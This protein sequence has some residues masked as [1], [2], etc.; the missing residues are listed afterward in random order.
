MI[1]ELKKYWRLVFVL[2]VLLL[3]TCG[4]TEP[5]RFSISF[6]WEQAPK[7]TV[8]L[9]VRI[10]ERAD[11]AEAG[12]I[13]AS[14]GPV[15]YV[16]GT[17]VGLSLEDVPNGDDRVVVVE[18]REGQDS[19]LPIAYFGLSEPFSLQPGQKG[20]VDVLVML[21][22]PNALLN[23]A[24]LKLL[25]DG[26]E[27]GTVGPDAIATATIQTWS[28]DA[29][30]VLLARD[31]SFTVDVMKVEL[32]GEDLSACGKKYDLDKEYTVCETSGVDLAGGAVNPPDGSYSIFAR[33]IDSYGYQS[34]VYKESV[35]LDSTGPQVITASA[36]PPFARAG[37][38]VVFSLTT[39]EPLGVD[40]DGAPKAVLTVLLLSGDA[41]TKPDFGTA[42]RIGTSNT[43]VWTALMPDSGIDI[44]TFG[45]GVELSD[46]VGNMSL[47]DPVTDS[48]NNT[49][50]LGVDGQPPV[51]VSEKT[52]QYSQDL[53]GLAGGLLVLDF[54]LAEASP[55]LSE[56]ELDSCAEGCPQ[57]RLGNQSVGE[58]LRKPDLDEPSLNRWGFSYSYSVDSIPWGS[59]EKDLEVSIIWSDQAGN[60]MEITLPETVRI[61]FKRPGCASQ[62][63]VPSSG[64]ATASFTYTL[65][66]SE[67][68]LLPPIVL[69]D[70]D[71]TVFFPGDSVTEAEDGQTFSWS[72]PAVDLVDG[73]FE[74]SAV[75]TDLAGNTS[76][77]P[78]CQVSAL[79]DSLAPSVVGVVISVFDGEL[80]LSPELPLRA[81]LSV[82][83][84]VTLS[85]DPEVP[86]LHLGTG[87]LKAG[88]DAPVQDDEGNLTWMFSRILDGTEGE[89][90]QVVEV[91]GTDSVGNTFTGTSAQSVILDFTP[92]VANCLLNPTVAKAG[93]VIQLHVNCSE[94]VLDSGPVLDCEVPF[95][96]VT[97]GPG[98]TSFMSTHQVD[99]GHED[100]TDYSC[101]VMLTDLAG[102]T[103][104]GPEACLVNG[105]IDATAPLV[106]GVSV[107][108]VP[109]VVGKSG[110][111]LLAVG[112]GDVVK[113]I[114]T[115]TE[116]QG[117]AADY[118]QVVLNIPGSSIAFMQTG[119]ELV[120]DGVVSYEY[121]LVLD[122][123]VDEAAEGYRAIQVLIADEAGNLMT[124]EKLGDVLMMVD[125][126]PPEAECVLI[127]QAADG[128]YPLDQKVLL[129]V[130]P[131]EE[132][133]GGG[134]PEL[135]EE[136]PDTIPAPFFS[137]DAETEYRFSGTVAAKHG[138]TDFNVR[139]LL[140]DLVGNQTDANSSACTSAVSGSVDGHAPEVLSVDLVPDT[141]ETAPG[142]PLCAGV[143]VT[144]TVKIVGTGN[145]PLVTLG[146][147][148]MSVTP[149][150]PEIM[151]DEVLQ[152][153]FT[154][155][156]DGTEGAN[157]TFAS[158]E[159]TDLAGN[160]TL[161]VEEDDY[162]TLDFE[163]PAVAHA[164]LFLSSPPGTNVFSATRVTNE[165]IVTLT[166][167]ASEILK[168]L[169]QILAE[170]GDVVFDFISS[171]DNAIPGKIYVF[172]AVKD[173][174]PTDGSAD[175]PVPVSVL[176]TD[177]AGNVSSQPL[178]LL[179]P[180][181]V[182]AQPPDVPGASMPDALRLYRAPVGSRDNGFVT[183]YEV[184]GC[185][186]SAAGTGWAWCPAE[187]IGAVEPN[188]T[189][190]A[191]IAMAGDSETICSDA[192]VGLGQADDDGKVVVTLF[193]DWPA[194]CVR[195]AD[196]AGNESP[197]LQVTTVE[198]VTNLHVADGE[199]PSMTPHRAFTAVTHEPGMP[200]PR[201][202]SNVPVAEEQL[203]ALAVPEESE[204]VVV[205]T[206]P[207]WRNVSRSNQ[208]LSWNNNAHAFDWVS[209]KLVNYRVGTV[210]FDGES[211]TD[212]IS[213]PAP[214]GRDHAA[215]GFD[216]VRGRMVLYGGYIYGGNDRFSDTWERIGET[217]IDVS[218]KISPFQLT[219]D[220]FVWDGV[221]Q[222][223]L[224]LGRLWDNSAIDAPFELWRWT[225][226]E[227]FALTPETTDLP[228][229]GLGFDPEPPPLVY[230]SLRARL[231]VL[232]WP[233]NTTRETWEWDGLDWELRESFSGI[234]YNNWCTQ[235]V[236][237]PGLG[238]VISNCSGESVFW[239]G[240][241]WNP[242]P[243]L[244]EG[245]DCALPGASLIYYDEA[246]TWLQWTMESA[247]Y[248]GISG[249]DGKYP[250][251]LSKGSSGGSGTSALAGDIVY[252]K[253][254][255][256]LVSASLKTDKWNNPYYDSTLY[257]SR[258]RGAWETDWQVVQDEWKGHVPAL[259]ALGW[260]PMTEQVHLLGGAF[261]DFVGYKVPYIQ[262]GF[263]NEETWESYPVAS[264]YA[265]MGL[266]NVVSY[267]TVEHLGLLL[268][269]TDT[270]EILAH[271]SPYHWKQ[272][273][274]HEPPEGLVGRPNLVYHPEL[275][276]VMT[277]IDGKTWMWDENGWVWLEE[278]QEPGSYP[279]PSGNDK[280][281]AFFFDTTRGRMMAFAQKAGT[282]ESRTWEF[283]GE[284]WEVLE[285][286][287]SPM[288][289]TGAQGAY[290]PGM[291]RGYVGRGEKVK[292]AGN[293]WCHGNVTDMWEFTPA[294]QRPH[295]VVDFDLN[296]DDG[297]FTSVQDPAPRSIA[298]I[299]LSGR[300]GG[301]SHTYGTGTADGA[302]MPGFKVHAAALTPFSWRLLEE[303]E[304]AIPDEIAQW[305]AV[306][307]NSD[308]ETVNNTVAAPP[309][310]WIDLDGHVRMAVSSRTAVGSS[311][312]PARVILD[313][314]ELS[315][316]Y[317]RGSVCEPGDICCSESGIW[318][319]DAPCRNDG[320]ETVGL[321]RAGTCVEY[322]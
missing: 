120:S 89:G 128:P 255:D 130:A 277:V 288:P 161:H 119:A 127:P 12:R 91:Q 203:A 42:S 282:C 38:D 184:R 126:T 100:V 321:C 272:Q 43:Y 280:D 244:P 31:E 112:H 163:P 247:N 177:L 317:R 171:V 293:D 223:L 148:P 265:F 251:S 117:L 151:P 236:F 72:Q 40:Q 230:D 64:N 310:N 50:E 225:G 3:W 290:M 183:T 106:S 254:S 300:S 14:D 159:V 136:F 176:L 115:V 234:E 291:G 86:V 36:S 301:S 274:L 322:K 172:S 190:S 170:S 125:F 215:M 24:K 228:S 75:V 158:V 208:G 185:P 253:S 58:V 141:V 13:L 149:E 29:V 299:V 92:P 237:H 93:D 160:T 292:D 305:V 233:D 240:E 276:K 267:V 231:I 78:V 248:I 144:T 118:P 167:T 55:M 279:I 246:T 154:R 316:V 65:T 287:N 218:P 48:D 268:A 278:G 222:Q 114:F 51:L 219:E 216:P 61:D 263:W 102:N 82:Q 129:Q 46:E 155:K 201:A 59:V 188:A 284:T 281:N 242:L 56:E 147:Q 11:P 304:T 302:S 192:L 121:E 306:V 296:G 182:D 189:V 94:P 308:F 174:L 30:A 87:V 97:G 135:V 66:A 68:L 122:A 205:T 9:W 134:Q 47:T 202:A 166:L 140:E 70:G 143:V 227:W 178:D 53:F 138:E 110:D 146:T 298:E 239:D 318:T 107:E 76:D 209:G 250:R 283:D 191:Y 314:V 245:T 16:D 33:F 81:G 241:Q 98:D 108:T 294:F 45:F 156:L 273:Y 39:Q 137:Y 17:P 312:E 133:A 71:E 123:I 80:V 103:N 179:Q 252:E 63:L 1:V 6:S 84:E 116:I 34:A 77:G 111:M 74:V 21:R 217:W 175:G 204:E 69:F 262:F 8:W 303:L 139:V 315:V 67:P 199:A 18:V 275:Q 10:E 52:S 157:I 271:D 168:E 238:K 266:Q 264:S 210:E 49:V 289:R 206:I 37:Q 131:F 221:H 270:D 26:E 259:Y 28:V 297:P 35:A 83:A 32:S 23:E 85:G 5:G 105:S 181:V 101:K 257:T 90:Q 4:G 109:V 295:I 193:A 19:G 269:F 285:V 256:S 194:I 260:D 186:A 57:V 226:E 311:R 309:R 261:Y 187:G 88:L 15:E 286:L 22:P 211:W 214:P 41:G 197:A 319:D 232:L 164:S 104:S 62:L 258:F 73:E 95:G 60:A 229:Y 145:Q 207:E 198:W 220:A 320:S 132:L 213:E 124:V 25:F 142:F 173:S 44:A 152:W 180:L 212:L 150:S 96:L 79:V 99:V 235:P 196:Q 113:G 195:Q 2:A 313:Y 7:G 20:D 200:P 249:C 224:L 153:Q 165:T 243:G 307:R 169:P 162:V 54:V 27:R